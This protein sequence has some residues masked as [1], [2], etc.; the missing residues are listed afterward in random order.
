MQVI[1]WHGHKCKLRFG[2]NILTDKHGKEQYKGLIVQSK[3]PKTIFL[4]AVI[5]TNHKHLDYFTPGIKNETNV[6][7]GEG[8]VK[9]KETQKGYLQWQKT[10]CAINNGNHKKWP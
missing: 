9:K 7:N 3:N 8:G 1:L 5:V 6:P 4:A 2:F 10:W